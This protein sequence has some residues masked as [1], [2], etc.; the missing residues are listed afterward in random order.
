MVHSCRSV[1]HVGWVRCEL[2]SVEVGS[3][4]FDCK[5]EFE[6]VVGLGFNNSV[7]EPGRRK[8]GVASSVSDGVIQ[9]C[10][11]IQ[12]S[13][14]VV[15]G[16][17]VFD[18]WSNYLT[19]FDHRDIVDNDDGGEPIGSNEADVFVVGGKDGPSQIFEVVKD[20]DPMVVV[21]CE[22][23]G[24]RVVCEELEFGFRGRVGR[25]C[26]QVGVWVAVSRIVCFASCKKGFPGGGEIHDN[27]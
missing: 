19:I 21:P 3:S 6:G 25:P 20:H 10:S 8:E 26:C 7:E 9:R 16:E 18:R 12:Q 1:G 4:L 2:G 17:N 24:A 15:A 14:Q 22:D 11:Q 5:N 23:G 13:L 27:G